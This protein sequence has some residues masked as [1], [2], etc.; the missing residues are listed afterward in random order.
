[1]DL[2]SL[3][4]KTAIVIGG[5]GGLGKAMATGLVDAGADV[6][7]SG[8]HQEAL[9]AAAKDIQE[10]TGGSIV[11]IAGDISTKAGAQAL[12]AKV[13]SIF[14]HIDI[15][16]NSAGVNIRVPSLEYS[17]ED[18]DT[19]QN[20][21]LK[22]VFLTC[23]AVANHMVE[24]GIHGKIINIGSINCQVVA[25][26]NIVSYIAAKGGIATM[27]KSL[28]VDWAQYGINVNCIAPGFFETELT[29]VLF[30]DPERKAKML[31]HIPM[32][33][34]GTPMDLAGL[35]V[36]LASP[37]S[38]YVNGQTIYVDGGWTCC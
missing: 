16:L 21:Q 6:V 36:F 38:D 15:L 8:R 12:V 17:E 9:D 3:K 33:R 26:P 34:F 7:I 11:G 5:A 2:F 22:G 1:M 32:N 27:T 19:V 30:Q 4:G 23:Q 29:K 25:A 10:K 13:A 31:S 24:K 35:A 37:A 14:G 28:A 18:W 20:V